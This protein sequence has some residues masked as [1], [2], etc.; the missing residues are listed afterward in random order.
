M[1]LI[2]EDN[3]Y[4]LFLSK[5]E[6]GKGFTKE[7]NNLYKIL[8]KNSFK[9][10]LNIPK[11]DF[12]AK[13]SK[14]INTILAEQYSNKIIENESL[15]KILLSCS[16]IVEQKYDKYIE[17]LG[18]QWKKYTYQKSHCRYNDKKDN[19]L[20]IYYFKNFTKH[21]SKNKKNKL[22]KFIIVS[23]KSKDNSNT[24]VKYMICENCC[25]TFF[26]KI[27]KNY[28]EYC[29]MK[30]H[31]TTSDLKASNKNLFLATVY[32]THCNFL[33][34]PKLLCQKCNKELYKKLKQ[35]NFYVLIKN[36]II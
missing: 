7:I 21:C 24:I 8:L 28:C 23:K 20:D 14:E 17:A 3:K 12:L 19:K 1:S 36:A 26:V 30:Y 29:N 9:N 27:F 15:E 25:K 34:N 4:K 32:P 33:F 5:L 6:K 35:M 2:T 16:D 22:S 11:I 31:S 18:S 10:I 13:I